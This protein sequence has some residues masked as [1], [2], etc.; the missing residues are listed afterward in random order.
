MLMLFMHFDTFFTLK[1]HTN[2]LVI[3][4][5]DFVGCVFLCPILKPGHIEEI[6]NHFSKC[7]R[8]KYIVYI[9]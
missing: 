4:V 5:F 2:P 1:V 8:E 9:L 7:Q 6:Q 3:N